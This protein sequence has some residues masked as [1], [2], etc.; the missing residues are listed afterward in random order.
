MN[1]KQSL[2]IAYVVLRSISP[3]EQIVGG[4]FKV[5][6]QTCGLASTEQQ[7]VP[8]CELVE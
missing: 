2:G 1:P 7:I 6:D 4:Q 5:D 3:V 8:V